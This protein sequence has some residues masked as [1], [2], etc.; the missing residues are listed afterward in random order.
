[1]GCGGIATGADA[2]EFLMAGATALQVGTARGARYR[3]R[4]GV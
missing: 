3:E 4:T 2:V 1:V